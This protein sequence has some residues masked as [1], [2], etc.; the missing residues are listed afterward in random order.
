MVTDE[1]AEKQRRD[2]RDPVLRRYAF[3][4]G[5]ALRSDA[6]EAEVWF[7]R[8]EYARAH[9][10]LPDGADAHTGW[11]ILPREFHDP[12]E[13]YEVRLRP[14]SHPDGLRYVGHVYAADGTRPVLVATTP[15]GM[16]GACRAWA[17]SRPWIRTA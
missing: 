16:E 6:E 7:L 12:S 8:D 1:D 15:L 5:Y 11:P 17:A 2:N 14:M 13:G 4:T 3:L 10:T 9:G